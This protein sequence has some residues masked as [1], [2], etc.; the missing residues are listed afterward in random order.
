MGSKVDVSF[1]RNKPEQLDKFV[2][3]LD[4]PFKTWMEA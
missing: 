3:F 4:G 1:I 2:K